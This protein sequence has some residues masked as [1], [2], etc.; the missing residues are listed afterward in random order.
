VL[1]S[2][3]SSAPG[4]FTTCAP[5]KSRACQTPKTGPVGSASTAI[6]P[7]VITSITGATTVAPADVAALTVASAS[8]VA[9]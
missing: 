3:Q 6:R 1:T 5:M 9:R 8:A 7:S 4:C 2:F